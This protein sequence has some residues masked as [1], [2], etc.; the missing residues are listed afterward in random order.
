M[1]HIC[2]RTLRKRLIRVLWRL[3]H[4]PWFYANPLA[5]AALWTAVARDIDAEWGTGDG[6]YCAIGE[7]IASIRARRVLDVG[8]G[9][10]RLFP[11]YASAG[12]LEVVGQDIARSALRL[13]RRRTRSFMVKLTALPVHRLRYPDGHFDLAICNR[14]L[15]HIPSSEIEKAVRAICRMSKAVYVNELAATDAVAEDVYMVLHD[16]DSLMGRCGYTLARTGQIGAQTW[17]LYRPSRN[18]M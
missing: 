13:C 14:V 9:S 12:V 7:V 11:L 8:C 4:R 6:D 17:R 15:Q 10:G 18:G 2:S 3:A 1:R 16:Y 5:R